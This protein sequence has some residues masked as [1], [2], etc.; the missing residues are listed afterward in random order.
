M[1][2]P[3]SHATIDLHDETRRRL[4]ARYGISG[5]YVGAAIV[6]RILGIGLTTVYEQAKGGRFVIPHRLANRKPL[7]LLDDLVA[8]MVGERA[9]A[10]RFP[11]APPPKLSQE[12]AQVFKHADA[13][14]AFQEVMRQRGVAVSKRR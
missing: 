10:R 7:F 12:H 13:E 5:E 9:S 11:P 14:A 1:E 2:L 8:W 6:A 4:A 3:D